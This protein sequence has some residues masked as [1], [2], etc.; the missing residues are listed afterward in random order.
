[1]AGQVTSNVGDACYAVALPWFVLAGHG[2]TVLLGTVLAASGIPRTAL[3]MAGGWA[4][5]RW[6]PQT[7]MLASDALRVVA[8]A[9]LAVT[10]AAGPARA[11]LLIPVA[12]VLSAGEGLFLPA[13]FSA[14]PSLLPADD[15]QAGNALASGGT[16]PA[17]LASRAGRSSP[18]RRRSSSRRWPSRP[19]RSSASSAG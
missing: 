7:V 19:P 18:G 13:S 9:A 2:G 16:Q 11:T 12:V 10:A 15:L 17:M 3:I 4:S 5:D 6:R 8:M 1:V 14:V